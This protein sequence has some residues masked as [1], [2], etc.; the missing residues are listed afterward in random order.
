MEFKKVVSK[1]AFIVLFIRKLRERDSDATSSFSD[2]FQIRRPGWM[3]WGVS[4][5]P[6]CWFYLAVLSSVI[7][8]PLPESGTMLVGVRCL[9]SDACGFR[10]TGDL[11]ST[12]RCVHALK[13]LALLAGGRGSGLGTFVSTLVSLYLVGFRSSYLVAA[14]DGRVLANTVDLVAGAGVD[15]VVRLGSVARHVD[16]FVGVV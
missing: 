14:V 15:N 12:A 7:S 1:E 4:W 6:F 3:E 10:H 16:E 5:F 9:G 8:W 2:I 11:V 13:G